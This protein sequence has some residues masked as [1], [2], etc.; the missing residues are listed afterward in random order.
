MDM[1]DEEEYVDY[2]DFSRIYR[3]HPLLIK[4]D[5]NAPKAL[6][7]PQVEVNAV[8]EVKDPA[9]KKEDQADADAG[10]EEDDGEGDDDDWVDED[11]Q[12]MQSA[13]ADEEVKD[14]VA[15]MPSKSG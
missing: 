7:A 10:K 1:E 15:E 2:Y 8:E 12:S 9:V 6:E 11:D 13:E 4:E 5:E 3:D 14:L